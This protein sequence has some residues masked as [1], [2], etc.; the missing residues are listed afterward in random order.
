MKKIK[1][2][3]SLILLL[4]MVMTTWVY[5]D[6]GDSSLNKVNI[7]YSTENLNYIERYSTSLKD[8]SQGGLRIS[9]FTSTTIPVDYLGLYVELQKKVGTSWMTVK[10]WGT[11]QKYNSNSISYDAPYAGEIGSQ[12][13]TIT[14]HSIKENGATEVVESISDYI[15]LQ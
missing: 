1:G 5:A 14:T 15:T 2:M 6:E 3:L 4:T 8:M 13:R 11:I 7:E 12:Y 9:T 10:T